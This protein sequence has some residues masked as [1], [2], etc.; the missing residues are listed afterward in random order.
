[1]PAFIVHTSDDQVVDVRNAIRLANAY[2]EKKIPFEMHIFKSAPH[3]M[4]LSNKITAGNCVAHDNP[5]NAKWVQLAAEWM[6]SV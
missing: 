2:A 5:H 4:A 6:K 1:M 3:G